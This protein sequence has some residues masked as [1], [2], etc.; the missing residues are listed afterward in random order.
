[1]GVG[2]FCYCNKPRGP[3]NESRANKDEEANC[4][5]SKNSKKQIITEP[6]LLFVESLHRRKR[7]EHL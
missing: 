2:A 6:N 4:Q 3:F 1:M 5:K 7:D